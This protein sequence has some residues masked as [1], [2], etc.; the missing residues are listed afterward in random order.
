VTDRDFPQT[1]P[2]RRQ[3][4]RRAGAG[5]GSLA[6]AAL[7]ADEASAAPPPANPLAPR[8]P[9]FPAGARRV[10]F[11]FMPGGPSQVDTF[12]P[13]PRLTRDHGKPAP[14][15]YL[16]QQRKL[17]ASPWRFR[18]QGQSG[19]EVSELFPHLGSSIDHLCVIRSMV[20][21][22][23]NHPGGCLQMNT[24]ERVATRPSL[25]A[26]V[27]Y[28]LGAENQNLPG[29]VA[30]GPGPLIEGARQYGAGF[31]PAAFQGTF[32]SDLR[33][34][35]RNLKNDRVSPARQRPYLDALRRLNDMHLADR[36]E[37]SRLSARIESFE[38]AFR[39]Q[40]QA[41][42]AFDLTRETEA[43]KRCYGIDQEATAVFGRQCLLARRL[44]E[45]GV[46]FVQLYHTTGGFQPWDQ[47]S[48][49]K[50][51]HARNALATDRPIAGLIQ[52]LQ[53][54]GLLEDTLLI[55]GGE[56]GRTPAAEG[57]DGRNH[58]PYGFTM[59]LAGG[60]VKGGLAHGATDEFGWDAVEDRVHVHDLHATILHLLGLDH[61]KLTYRHS[62]RDFRL[63]D[64]YGNVVKSIIA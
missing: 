17:L 13:K 15:L 22:D 48:D 30:I 35:I 23:V 61:E 38:L 34:P 29:F 33:N 3:V 31:L 36:A 8:P 49:L 41:P 2:T 57:Q 47:H 54:R 28:G 60:G 52:D 53:A 20:A 24:G 6:L 42:D 16:G 63:T 50:G 5:F 39:M 46:R 7:L 25:G 62:G 1:L 12:D 58:H 18:K 59:W 55:W 21:D 10:I 19:L 43:T 14:K 40:S 4:L 27:T 9:H 26:W 32:V 37:D 64:V 45:R 11:L 51:G 56:F 44:V